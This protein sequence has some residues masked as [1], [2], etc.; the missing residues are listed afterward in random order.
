MQLAAM[1]D[2][3][4]R[5]VGTHDFRHFC[6][7]DPS[8]PST[9]V[10]GSGG[11]GG[12][13]DDDSGCVRTIVAFDVRLLDAT[14]SSSSPA[15]GRLCELRVRGTAFLWH[16]V[17][18]MAAVLFRIGTG[19]DTP[20]IVTR[21]LDV[22]TTRDRP[23]Y[24]MARDLPLVL[25]EAVCDDV[26]WRRTATTKPLDAFAELAESLAIKLAI[27]DGMIAAE[28]ENFVLS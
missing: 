21:M 28:A 25:H 24:N 18:C 14:S 2:G 23:R 13:N 12:T 27:I 19:L 22:S 20:D 11:S 15:R 17:R 26:A 3:A 6:K 5:F 7:A 1:R 9:L 16:Q 8:K 10:G 4:R